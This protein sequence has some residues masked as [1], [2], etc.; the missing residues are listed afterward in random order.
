[1]KHVIEITETLQR[2]IEIETIDVE[3]ALSVT[4]RLYKDEKIILDSSDYLDTEF[5]V[6]S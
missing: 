1:M 2:I 6:L 3:T 4:R 5:T